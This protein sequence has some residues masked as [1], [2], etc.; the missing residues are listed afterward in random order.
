MTKVNVSKAVAE[1]FIVFSS[2]IIL[3]GF[4][5]HGSPVREA[6]SMIVFNTAMVWLVTCMAFAANRGDKK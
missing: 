5:D 2:I 3:L 6:W 4:A 1:S